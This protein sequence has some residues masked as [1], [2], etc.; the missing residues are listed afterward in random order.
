MTEPRHLVY[1]A[2][3]MCS[4]CY[5]FG[6]ELEA[7]LLD[8][9]VSRIDLVMGGLRAFNAEVTTPAF[10]ATIAGHWAH[11]AMETGLPFNDGALAREG[12]VYDTEPACRA[13]V[14]IRAADPAR[15]L[16]FMRQ[17]QHAF[18]AKGRDVT[19]AEVLAD[20]AS[21]QGCDRAAFLEA[22]AS[23]VTKDAA[24]DDFA[25]TQRSGV[26]GFPT[27]AVGYPDGR[28]FLVAVGF[29]RAATLAERLDRIDA[30]ASGE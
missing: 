6:P 17:V 26:T 7:L 11:V 10:R 3:P 13:V 8:H 9:P 14:A 22:F 27:L 5:G 24:R 1:F 18:Y 2:D 25:A 15:A 30:A 21:A 28:H 29:T 19:D 16:P 12:F 20:V 23:D 4:W